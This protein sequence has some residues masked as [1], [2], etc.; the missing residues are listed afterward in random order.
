MASPSWVVPLVNAALLNIGDALSLV[1]DPVTV[2]PSD[3]TTFSGRI[4]VGMVVVLD[5]PAGFVP[6]IL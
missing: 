1:A 2:T 4:S 6:T 5:P 3:M